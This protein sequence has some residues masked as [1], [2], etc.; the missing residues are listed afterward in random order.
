MLGHWWFSTWEVT[1]DLGNLSGVMEKTRLQWM[2]DDESESRHQAKGK[3]K[4]KKAL[5]SFYKRN[6]CLKLTKYR[7]T[8]LRDRDLSFIFINTE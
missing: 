8:S 6:I 1:G 4:R 2:K 7:I 3:R 5:G